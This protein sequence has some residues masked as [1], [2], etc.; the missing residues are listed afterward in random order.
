MTSS[1]CDLDLLTV[2]ETPIENAEDGRARRLSTRSLCHTKGSSPIPGFASSMFSMPTPFPPSS[3]REGQGENSTS[4]TD[5]KTMSLSLILSS[6][7]KTSNVYVSSFGTSH[8]PQVAPLLPDV[9]ILTAALSVNSICSRSRGHRCFWSLEHPYENLFRSTV[10]RIDQ[11]RKRGCTF[12]EGYPE[13]GHRFN[14]CTTLIPDKFAGGTGKQF[15]TGKGVER[16]ASYII[17]IAN[18]HLGL[19]Y[20][21]RARR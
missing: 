3:N 4:Y 11:G 17:T 1:H 21:A 2:I 8:K 9:R 15:V 10:E 6:R 12:A 18:M 13:I 5:T 14:L 20:S 16:H 19:I 7:Q